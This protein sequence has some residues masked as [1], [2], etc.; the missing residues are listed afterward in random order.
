MTTLGATIGGPTGGPEGILV[1]PPGLDM[2]IGHPS[3]VTTFGATD[4]SIGGPTRCPE[5]SLRDPPGL[6]CARA[7]SMAAGAMHGPGDCT[8]EAS[9]AGKGEAKTGTDAEV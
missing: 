9:G 8:G 1:G 3:I 5:G 4:G 6:G 2:P 7:A